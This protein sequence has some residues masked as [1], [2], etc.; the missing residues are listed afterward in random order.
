M[1]LA[2]SI[3]QMAAV[4]VGEV[5]SGVTIQPNADCGEGIPHTS[6][7]ILKLVQAPVECQQESTRLLRAC[8][9]FVVLSMLHDGG[10]R[11]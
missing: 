8:E 3:N 11:W 10:V 7:P 1:P 4:N 5:S 9:C 2:C 6:C